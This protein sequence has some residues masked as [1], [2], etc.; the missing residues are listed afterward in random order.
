MV[1]GMANVAGKIGMKVITIAVG[2]PV[3]IATRKAVERIWVAAGPDRPR[4][5]TDDGVQ[6]ADAIGWAA[7]T[8]IGMTVADLLTRKGA[9]EIYRTAFE[10]KPPTAKPWASRRVARADPKFPEAVAPPS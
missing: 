3:S 10:K 4:Q 5:A 9:E 6:W 2:I 7:L 1:S 8:A